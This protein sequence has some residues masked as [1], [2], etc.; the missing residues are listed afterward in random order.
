MHSVGNVLKLGDFTALLTTEARGMMKSMIALRYLL[1]LS[2]L[3]MTTMMEILGSP[4]HLLAQGRQWI[5]YAQ[6]PVHSR[7]TNHRPIS[8][9]FNTPQYSTNNPVEIFPVFDANGE[10]R[11]AQRMSKRTTKR[12]SGRQ[13]AMTVTTVIPTWVKT[14][15]SSFSWNQ[16]CWHGPTAL[17]NTQITIIKGRLVFFACLFTNRVYETFFSKRQSSL[18]LV[19]DWESSSFDPGKHLIICRFSILI[20]FL[21]LWIK[22]PRRNP[23]QKIHEVYAY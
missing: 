23:I 9:A 11:S 10:S 17:W 13:T 5:N 19:A 7:A 14:T 1:R 20:K 3:M 22:S 18:S 16:W 2:L 6:K 15:L 8:W 21:R 4:L 12:T